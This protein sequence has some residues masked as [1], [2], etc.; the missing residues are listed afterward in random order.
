MHACMVAPFAGMK[1]PV[2]SSISFGPS[3]GEQIEI[4]LY[5]TREAIEAGLKELAEL[6]EKVN[7]N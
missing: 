6:K 3:F 4:G 2:M 7:E 1:I 5:P